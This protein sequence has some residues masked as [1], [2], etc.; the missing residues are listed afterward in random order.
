[1]PVLNTICCSDLISLAKYSEGS[2]FL[3]RSDL[4]LPEIRHIPDEHPPN[5][6]YERFY[7]DN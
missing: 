4:Q 7:A 3:L 2:I 6:E 5:P 1:M